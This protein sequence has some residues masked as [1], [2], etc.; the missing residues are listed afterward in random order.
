M[1]NELFRLVYCSRNT[2]IGQQRD[3]A[4][5]VGSI[6]AASRSNNA[7]DGVTGALLYSDGCFAQALEGELDAVQR[8]FERI[9]CDPRHGDVIVLQAGRA[10]GRLFGAWS[11][12]LAEA[13]DPAKASATL[14][15]ALA[16]QNADAGMGA[17]VVALLEGLVR[18]QGD[19]AHASA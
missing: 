1:S 8:T 9:Q 17:D 11:M 5:E 2:I 6:L 7:R 18:R 13:A 12:A 10:I 14:T 16:Q 4:V 3:P 19:W 15:R